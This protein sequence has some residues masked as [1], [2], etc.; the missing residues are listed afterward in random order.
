MQPGKDRKIFFFFFFL[1]NQVRFS[2]HQFFRSYPLIADLFQ[3]ANIEL[4]RGNDRNSN[5]VYHE[6]KKSY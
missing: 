5:N 4:R 6:M 2:F 1:F 3:S